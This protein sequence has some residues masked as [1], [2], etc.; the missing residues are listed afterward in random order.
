[1]IEK[2]LTKQSEILSKKEYTGEKYRE[3]RYRSMSILMAAINF[4]GI[5]IA[6]DSRSVT[7]NSP[8]GIRVLND[9]TKKV[10]STK[11][12]IVGTWGSN[13]VMKNAIQIDLS[14]MI[15]KAIENAKTAA[16]FIQN[17]TKQHLSQNYLLYDGYYFVIGEKGKSSPVLYEYSINREKVVL[18]SAHMEP[19]VFVFATTGM[20]PDY[21][22]IEPNQPL[23]NLKDKFSDCIR[24]VCEYGEILVKNGIVSAYHVGGPVQTEVL[25]N[26]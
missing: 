9:D 10:F 23:K 19:G 4:S 26:I 24:S 13:V 20:F 11:D 22:K 14:Y 5:V 17:F 6:S 3:G 2:K 25:H 21:A 7:L 12:L 16:D 15:E 1:M 18:D 8:Y